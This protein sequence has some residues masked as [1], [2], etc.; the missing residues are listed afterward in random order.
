M[1][2]VDI[3]RRFLPRSQNWGFGAVE[4]INS[5][6]PRIIANA[7]LSFDAKRQMDKFVLK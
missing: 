6:W 5:E 2:K 4:R 3:E 1:L 7:L